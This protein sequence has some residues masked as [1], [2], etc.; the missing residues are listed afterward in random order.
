MEGSLLGQQQNRCSIHRFLHAHSFPSH[1]EM[2]KSF[3]VRW[4]ASLQICS[5]RHQYE[6]ESLAVVRIT[7]PFFSSPLRASSFID[8]KFFTV[9]QL[10]FCGLGFFFFFS[11]VFLFCTPLYVTCV[12]WGSSCQAC[13][14]CMA[15]S[16]SKLVFPFPSYE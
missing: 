3:Q 8:F 9:D 1:L 14:F 6:M 10:S 2:Q 12:N 4:K 16:S 13:V 7:A 5:S 15:Q 11:V